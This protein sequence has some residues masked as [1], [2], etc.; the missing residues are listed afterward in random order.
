LG[1]EGPF[2]HLTLRELAHSLTKDGAA[3]LRFDYSGYGDSAGTDEPPHQVEHW[4]SDVQNAIDEVKRLAPSDGPVVLVG[5]RAG[6]LLA[7]AAAHARDDVTALVLW[8]PCLSGKLFMREQR[9]F[10]R[11][12]HI[13]A[14]S[15]GMSE[16]EWGAKGFEANGY[17][18]TDDTI[19][20][21]SNLDARSM[22]IPSV[23]SILL[24]DRTEAPV[25]DAFPEA[26]RQSGIAVSQAAI[27]G[28]AEFM[29]PPWISVRPE[30]ALQK[31]TRWTDQLSSQRIS[32]IPQV[33]TEESPSALVQPNVIETPLW[34]DQTRRH[35]GV[36][37]EPVDGPASHAL[38][39]I[40]ST[41][42]YR[43]GPN[44]MHVAAA[45]HFATLGIATLRFDLP[46]TGDSR[47]QDFGRAKVP[48]DLSAVA[49]VQRAYHCLVKRGYTKIALG[50]VCAGAFMAWHTGLV[51]NE[52][53]QLLLVNPETFRP[54]RYEL[55]DHQ[56]MLQGHLDWREL[57]RR[58]RNPLALI[59][60]LASRGRTA[61]KMAIDYAVARLPAMFAPAS[62]A[63]QINKIGARGTRLSIIFSSE[64]LGIEELRRQLGPHLSRQQNRGYL[65]TSYI[66]GADHSFT[67]RW[68]TQTLIAQMAHELIRWSHGP[69]AR[70]HAQP[71]VTQ[72]QECPVQ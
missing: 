70:T 49:D 59:R 8:A 11:L 57:L 12:A 47:I 4:I 48:Y 17:V 21:F 43:I 10:S 35:F 18:F 69:S 39:M 65:V 58:E 27:P 46:Q 26:W 50:G 55:R 15:R 67:P 37:T 5:L 61:S 60:V 51:T 66:D 34:L 28:Y 19:A 29:E 44:R 14:A 25:D 71:T 13:T 1:Y 9:A 72:I 40:T 20:G 64:D 6:A 3:V 7:C 23:T 41:F 31:I 32:P 42:G 33:A 56:K 2:S 62:L 36:L 16:G 38:V 63:V 54:I 22:Q 52:V 68:A 30:Q 24:L 53:S 45:R